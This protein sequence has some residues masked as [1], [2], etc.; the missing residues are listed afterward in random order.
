MNKEDEGR[1][2]ERCGATEEETG[3]DMV[4]NSQGEPMCEECMEA[5]EEEQE[6]DLK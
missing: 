2:C 3:F 4:F 5:F 1:I 6:E